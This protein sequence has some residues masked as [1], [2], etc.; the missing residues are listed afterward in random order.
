M[1]NNMQCLGKVL[2]LDLRSRLNYHYSHIIHSLNFPIDLCDENFFIEWNSESIC[3]KIIKNKEK[4]NLLKS[5]KRLFIYIIASHYDIS[6]LFQGAG[7][8]FNDEYMKSLLKNNLI[9]KS[10]Q[11]DDVRYS[12][13]HLDTLTQECI[14]PSESFKERKNQRNLP[15]Y[16]WF[17]ILCRKISI[18]LQIQNRH[19][20]PQTVLNIH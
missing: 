14:P 12:L 16:K 1:Y 10:N 4:V 13:K 20:L 15:E 8:L 3:K 18:P 11:H 5:R 19:P 6:A 9:V 2:I 7:Q 17:P